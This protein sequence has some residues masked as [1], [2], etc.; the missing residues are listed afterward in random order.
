MVDPILSVLPQTRTTKMGHKGTFGGSGYD[1]HLE[2]YLDCGA[3][4]VVA[5][6]CPNSSNC[7]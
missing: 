7:I 5:F 3:G 1:W 4:F 2:W 6:V